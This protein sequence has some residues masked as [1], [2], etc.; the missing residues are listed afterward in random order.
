MLIGLLSLIW[1][2]PVAAQERAKLEGHRGRIE[3]LAFSP[4]GQWLVSAS[5]Y[6]DDPVRVWDVA[7]AKEI[8]ALKPFRLG[9]Y[10]VAFAP[11]GKTLLTN[12]G[13]G[14][15]VR[16]YDT[17]TWKVRATLPG[18][19]GNAHW[20]GYAPD[21][22]HIATVTNGDF[23]Q[24]WDAR[25]LK[26]ARQFGGGV[27][28]LRTLAFSPDG[29]LAVGGGWKQAAVWDVAS[30]KKLADLEGHKS[31]VQSVAFAPDGKTLATLDTGFFKD[32]RN[33]FVWDARTFQRKYR[34]DVGNFYTEMRGLAFSPDSRTL[35]VVGQ[36][37][38]HLWEAATGKH[39]AQL[40]ANE[41]S[42]CVA[43]CPSR[44]VLAVGMVDG[45]V[46]L[47]DLPRPQ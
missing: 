47:L 32:K 13:P 28:R 24:L 41:I 14:D 22:Q 7:A 35:A 3:A 15:P 18:T 45:T 46:R 25:S 33:A 4:D 8:Q 19:D 36:R 34:L 29:K 21:G 1:A 38:V 42:E 2:A 30:G 16:L 39:Q 27:A 17:A 11:D 9:T 20:L 10:R 12:G 37:G 5:W 40:P 44:R 6:P 31:Q 23:V 43:F 26:P